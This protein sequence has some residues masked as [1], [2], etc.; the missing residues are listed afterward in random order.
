MNKDKKDFS[1]SCPMPITDYK[2]I[3]LGHGSGGTLSNQLIEKIFVNTFDNEHLRRGHDS[4]VVTL[5]DTKIAITTDSYVIDPIFFPGGDIGSLSIHGTI[6][7]LAMSGAEPLYI[8]T[9][10]IIE[11]GYEVAKLYEIV[12]SMKKAAD[13]AGVQIVTGDTKVVDKGKGDGVFINTSGIG[14]IK[15]SLDISPSSIKEGDIIILSGDIARH[16]ISVMAA[17]EKINMTEELISDSA[18]L[19][20]IVKE[21]IDEGIKI[22]CMRDLTRGG[23]ASAL[24]EISKTSG[25]QIQVEEENIP[26]SNQVHSLCEIFGFD[27]MYVANE[28]RFI[29][30]ASDD[31][32]EKVVSIMKKHKES[33]EASIIGKVISSK[34]AIVTVKST[35]GTERIVDMLPGEQLP[36][37]C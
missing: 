31:D 19:S 8:S 4:S 30:F 21:I 20:H 7:D 24:V 25:K 26:V 2:N 23:L 36:R 33:A 15:H 6:N 9:G 32:K 18:S 3:L 29:C 11:E 27:P 34:E 13:L 37:I 22:S 17:R 10:F 16:G 14:V 28:G 35:I 5:V 1:Y 12:K